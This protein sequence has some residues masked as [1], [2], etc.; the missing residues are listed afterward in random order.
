MK[1]IFIPMILI[2]LTV[3]ATAQVCWMEQEVKINR[4]WNWT[5]QD[6]VKTGREIGDCR[7][8][9]DNITYN[10]TIEQTIIQGGGGVSKNW[11]RESIEEAFSYLTDQL[12]DCLNKLLDIEKRL[13]ALE[14]TA[15]LISSR[16][17]CQGRID[18]MI[19]YNL[20]NVSCGETTYYNTDF[21][22]VGIRGIE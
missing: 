8:A 9:C 19:E 17:Y 3:A 4:T 2:L 13:F 5:K 18:M 20:T 21:G 15:E 1:L 7:V 22:I 6:C 16:D 12:T 14:R 11:V 10:Q